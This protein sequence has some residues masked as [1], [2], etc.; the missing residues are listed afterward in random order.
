H[1]AARVPG[2]GELPDAP[3]PPVRRGHP[4]HHVLMARRVPA[5]LQPLLD[6]LYDGYNVADSAADPVQFVWRYDDADDR[7][8]VALIAASLAFGRLAS[9]L[10]TIERVLGVLGPSPAAWVRDMD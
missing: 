10:A 9:V 2:L 1:R 8:V 4:A 3:V 7:E 6:E 5:G